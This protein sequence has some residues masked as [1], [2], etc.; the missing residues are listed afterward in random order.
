MNPKEVKIADYTYE[1]PA[2]RI[3]K[4]PL[5]KRDESKLLVYE[6]DEISDDYFKNIQQRL[7]ENS[8]LIFNDS[9]VI[10][11][12]ILLENKN[13]GRIEVFCL[14]SVSE[15]KQQAIWKCM[16]GGASKWK[17]DFLVKEINNQKIQLRIIE[18]TDGQFLIEFEWNEAIENMA[19]A[20]E[21]FGKIPIPPYLKR[22]TEEI[23]KERYQNVFANHDGSVAAPTAGLHFTDELLQRLNSD[24]ID[25]DFVTLHVGAG[26]F[27]PV[28]TETLGGHKMHREQVI[29]T[30]E[31]IEKQIELH[32]KK[33]I[34]SVGTTSLR[35]L[36]SLYWIGNLL[37]QNPPLKPAD[38]LVEQ[39]LPYKSKHKISVQQS[40]QAILNRLEKEEQSLFS[41]HTELLILPSYSFRMANYLLTNFHQPNS[42]LLLLVA[43]AVGPN[44]QTIYQHALDN[45]YRFL[46]YGDASLIQL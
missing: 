37:D 36:E 19:M 22:N 18:K 6:N 23:D 20:L 45:D 40:L 4:Y 13:G 14:E 41:F 35:S 10:P 28:K 1:L 39:W 11:V 43:A 32:E 42:T 31:F 38:L 30:K 33:N 34:V 9:R 27:Q 7:P 29:V 3:A 15:I 25:L 17:E 24:K 5:P 8:W 16:V 44:W 21:I 12:R 2:E 26:T 46:S